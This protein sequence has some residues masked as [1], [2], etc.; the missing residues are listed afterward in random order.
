ML[1][2]PNSNAFLFIFFTNSSVDPA[3]NSASATAASFAEF[4]MS[5]YIKLSTVICSPVRRNISEP[6]A[7]FTSGDTVT[8]EFRS[9]SSR[10]TI[11]VIN[12][13]MDA[14]W[15]FVWIDFSNRTSPVWLSI[16]IDEAALMTGA[17]KPSFLIGIGLTESRSKKSSFAMLTLASSIIGMFSFVGRARIGWSAAVM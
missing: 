5:P 17:M 15:R 7:Y 2:S 10:M 8:I 13:V 6:S 3:L 9:L 12:F 16:A 1:S 11:A 14:I 4:M